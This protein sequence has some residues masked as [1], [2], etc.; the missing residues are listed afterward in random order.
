MKYLITLFILTS[1]VL[2]T[3]AQKVAGVYK[4]IMEV[5]SP[6][7]TINF[8]LT[9]Q[10]K[11][12]KLTG[13]CHRQFLVGDTLLYNLVKVTAKIKNNILV[14]EDDYSVSNNFPYYNKNRKTS[15]YFRLEDI[16]DTALVL[17][18]EWKINAW[19]DIMA[20]SG[21]VTVNRER[22]Y[23]K[24]QLYSRLAEVKKLDEV[25]F[26]PP[27]IAAA[28]PTTMGKDSLGLM[29]NANPNQAGSDSA[30]VFAAKPGIGAPK[31]AVQKITL[32]KRVAEPVQAKSYDIFEDSVTLAL[33]D[34]GEIDG[35]I[36]SLILN[37]VPIASQI[38]L[39]EKP[40]K[41][42]VAV[43]RNQVNRLE[44]YAE[45]LGKTPPNTGLVVINTG[46]QR[47][48]IFFTASLQKNAIVYLERK[49]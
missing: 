1:T 16:A 18:G 35:D 14:V 41:I 28:N 4:G 49:D 42:T 33:Y 2:Q 24:T 45:S 12:G 20:L 19:A 34:N 17:P 47:Y 40:F 48:Q 5:D 11:N 39:T 7:N 29:A 15:F 46:S 13:F 36:V 32:E 43:P 27:V 44:L 22:E 23:K 3:E 38:S 21:K 9:L 6:K 30:L 26:E 10:Q 31:I 25:G 37:D 8:E